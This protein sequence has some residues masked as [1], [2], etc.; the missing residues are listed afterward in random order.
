MIA[1]VQRGSFDWKVKSGY[2]ERGDPDAPSYGSFNEKNASERDE[3]DL[4]RPVEIDIENPHN[5]YM[6]VAVS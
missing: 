1:R 3:G 2:Q 6:A 4:F 5:I